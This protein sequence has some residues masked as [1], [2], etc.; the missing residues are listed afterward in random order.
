MN[1]NKLAIHQGTL[2]HLPTD[3]FLIQSAAAFRNVSLWHPSIETFL[4]SGHSLAELRQLIDK[5]EIRIIEFSHLYNWNLT[6]KEE[7]K[8]SHAN[9]EIFCGMAQ[10]LKAECICVPA[11]GK[12]VDFAQAKKNL[13]AVVDIATD[14]DLKVALEFIPEQ[15]LDCLSKAWDMVREINR[16]KLGLVLDTAL[17]AKSSSKLADI[18]EVPIEK[19]FL[20]HLADLLIIPGI[21]IIT[22]MRNYRK[23]PGFGNLNLEPLLQKLQKKNYQGY[24]SLEVFDKEFS[25]LDVNTILKQVINSITSFSSQ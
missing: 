1:L 18:D 16:D 2:L 4:N 15:D 22:L 10:Q 25:S 20:V 6:S 9:T 8:I 13:I 14:Y 21:E 3:E 23:L 11:F 19:I 24:Y 7:Q 17:F 5:L 12:G